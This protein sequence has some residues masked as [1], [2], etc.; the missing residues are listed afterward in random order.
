M[1]DSHDTNV[2]SVPE[3][4][5]RLH[6]TATLLQNASGLDAGLR[7]TLTELLQ[8]LGTALAQPAAPPAEVARLAESVAHLADALHA[9]HDQGLVAGARDRLERFMVQAESHAPTAVGL[10]QR[11]IDAIANLGI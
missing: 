10:A 2:P 8:E 6:E 9:R 3:V 5:A 1:A 4:R 7:Q 11:L